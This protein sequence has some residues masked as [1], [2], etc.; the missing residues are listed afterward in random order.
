MS[1]SEWY[2]NF[3]CVARKD[4]YDEMLLKKEALQKKFIAMCSK[5]EIEASKINKKEKNNIHNNKKRQKDSLSDKEKLLMAEIKKYKK[6]IQKLKKSN[7]KLKKDRYLYSEDIKSKTEEF[8]IYK[9]MLDSKLKEIDNLKEENRQLR[10]RLEAAYNID[11]NKEL[12]AVKTE[13]FKLKQA[14]SSLTGRLKIANKQLQNYQQIR[15]GVV[16][17]RLI[18]KYQ[19]NIKEKENELDNLKAKY[20]SATAT[21]NILNNRMLNRKKK[22]IVEKSEKHK[23]KTIENIDDKAVDKNIIFGFLSLNK[24]LEIIFIDLNNR[25]YAVKNKISDSDVSKYIGM[26]TRVI[27]LEDGFVK[28]DYVYY[29]LVTGAK[30]KAINKDRTFKIRNKNKDKEVYVL[31]DEFKDKKILIVGSKN[32]DKYISAFKSSGADVLWYDSFSD[33]ESRLEDMSSS[34]DVVIVCTSHVSHGAMYKLY[35]LEDIKNNAKYQLIENDNIN[36]IVSRVRYA[37]ENTVEMV[38]EN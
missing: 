22:N 28:L 13:N 27:K 34:S 25:R 32:K 14:Q 6:D 5:K 35:S 24:D 20:I 2:G 4:N 26:P 17:S 12:A 23:R 21:I 10:E 18:K 15:N 37:L 29:N 16:E 8:N 1:K 19:I 33:N 11:L 38:V 36:N 3:D 31:R 7:D 9:N 30:I